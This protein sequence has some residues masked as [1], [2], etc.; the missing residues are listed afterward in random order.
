[1]LKKFLLALAI[2]ASAISF[3]AQS[4]DHTLC[5]GIIEENDMQIPISP[6]NT[7][8]ISEADFNKVLDTV[9]SYYKPIIDR[10]GG[11]LNIRRLWSN[12]TVNASAQRSGDEYVINMYGG[13]AR[14]PAI[15]KDGFMLVACHEMGHHI[16]GA[17]KSGW[18]GWASNEGQ[19]DYFANLKCLRAL[20]TDQ[21]NADFV[22]NTEIPAQVQTDCQEAFQT[23]VDENQCMR[24]AMAGL[25]VSLLFKSVRKESEDPKFNTPDPEHVRE[26]QDDHPATQCRLDTYFQG[27]LCTKNLSEGLDD[28]NPAIGTC[29]YGHQFTSGLRPLCWYKP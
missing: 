25:S 24:A 22:A 12:N 20:F 13:L 6:R 27:A 11:N 15:T 9:N 19:S 8:G 21:E 28:E 29:E 26:T 1:M 18:F 4:H 14:H 7:G 5:Q 17:P 2:S 10:Q 3:Y 16:G 23:Q